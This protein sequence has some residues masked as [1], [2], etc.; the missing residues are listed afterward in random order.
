MKITDENK[1]QVRWFARILRDMKV[2]QETGMYITTLLKDEKQ[3]DALV[4]YIKE[5]L[6]ATEAE[7]LDKATEISN[8]R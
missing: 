7:I 8:I 1:E 3:M 5:N 2:P 6:N 4:A